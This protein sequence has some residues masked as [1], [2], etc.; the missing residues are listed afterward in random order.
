[1]DQNR[2]NAFEIA[3]S[4]FPHTKEIIWLNSASQAPFSSEIEKD[5]TAYLRMR[6][7]SKVDDHHGLMVTSDKL[8]QDFAKLIGAD[9][10]EVGLGSN[11]T[12]GHNLAAFGLPLREGSEILL[13]DVE[14]P[15]AVYTWQT[16]AKARGFKIKFV[17]SHN[18]RFCIDEFSRC[19]GKK[20][21]VL[22]L[23][24]V[25]F[26][27]GYKNDLKAIGEICRAHGLY[28]VIDGIQ[29]MGTEPINVHELGIDIFT[30]GAQKWLLSP[31]GGGF[32]Y[33]SDK[34]RSE[35][36]SP[37]ASWLDVD[38]QGEYGD[39]FR[40]QLPI[41]DGA[42]RYE[43]GYNSVMNIVSLVPSI[44]LISDLGLANIQRHNQGLIDHLAA[45][46][47]KS[48][49]YRITSSME[50]KH[51]SSIFTFTCDKLEVL[52]EQVRGKQI[53][54]V[55]REG[56]MRVSPHLFNNLDDIDRLIAELDKFAS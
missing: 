10:Q 8:R 1:M 31:Q 2:E 9:R 41:L 54:T 23:S 16:A 49:D 17:K 21:K 7:E 38:W 42:R 24:W 29:G 5:V 35:I 52:H 4:L 19:I 25:Q 13:S 39:L 53:M 12:F 34:T 37:F 40:Y 51:R 44:R 48:S 20:T 14:F 18:Q 27:N 22:C 47:D 3:R 50:S 30:A 36:I 32:F 6:V 33:I 45:Y 43:M 46:I 26:F 28:F 55:C 15:A 56:S 11:T